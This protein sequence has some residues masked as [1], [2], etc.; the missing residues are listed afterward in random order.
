MTIVT[1]GW[2]LILLGIA[3]IAMLCVF[4]VLLMR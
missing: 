3:C 1:M 4:I 2:L